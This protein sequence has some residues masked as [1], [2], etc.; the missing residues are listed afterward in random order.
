MGQGAERSLPVSGRAPC[1]ASRRWTA[2]RGGGQGL[3]DAEE[4]TGLFVFA[5]ARG[6]ALGESLASL[7]LSGPGPGPFVLD[8]NS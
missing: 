4:G 6:G 2:A 8:A 1:R 7:V 5:A 3:A